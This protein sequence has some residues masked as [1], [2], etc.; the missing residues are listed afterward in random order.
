MTPS[1]SNTLRRCPSTVFVLRTRRA[2]IVDF[3][4]P[5]VTEHGTWPEFDLILAQR[6]AALGGS[7]QL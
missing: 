5:V 4:G 7:L 6:C 2:A 3:H 1:F